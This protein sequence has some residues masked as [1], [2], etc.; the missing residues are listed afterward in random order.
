MRRFLFLAWLGSLPL[1]TACNQGSVPAPV[2]SAT[3]LSGGVAVIDLDEVARLLGREVS[4]KQSL[5]AQESSLNQQLETLR[6][7]YANQLNQRKQELPEQPAEG[8]IAQVQALEQQAVAQIQQARQQAQNELQGQK[9]DLITAFREEVKP[10]ASQVAAAKGLSLVVSKNDTFLF[11]F[12]SAVDITKDVV[13]QMNTNKANG[14]A[15]ISNSPASSSLT[16]PAA[17]EYRTGSLPASS[18]LATPAE[19]GL[20]P[21]APQRPLR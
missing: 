12:D 1:W 3:Q 13:A 8:E 15:E 17:L 16:P 19:P 7:S 4:I 10:I 21:S 2:A 5:T 9:R 14:P 6:V 11:A 20:L 18:S